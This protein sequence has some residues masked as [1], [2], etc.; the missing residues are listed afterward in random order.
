[1][2]HEIITPKRDVYIISSGAVA[3]H[4]EEAGPLGGS[5]DAVD[6]NEDR[7]GEDTW[8]KAESEMQRLAVGFALEKAGCDTTSVGAMLAGDLLNQCVGSNYGLTSY[9]IPYMGLYG[10]CSTASEGMLLGSLL[11][12]S[13]IDRAL[14]VTSSH[15]CS[16]ERQFRFPLEYG[17]QR[18][19]TAQWTVTGSGAFLLSGV[20]DDIKQL[21]S[22]YVPRIAEVLPGYVVDRGISDVNNM[23][24]AMAPAAADTLQRYFK[25]GRDPKD[26]DL[27]ITG[28]LGSEG[29]GIL[30]ELLAEEGIDISDSHVDCGC[31]IYNADE[32]DKHAGGSGCGC[33]AVVM[34]AH[35]LKNI[36]EGVVS[37]VLFVGTGALMSPLVLSQG[38]SIPGIGHLVRIK[39]EKVGK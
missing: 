20:R 21:D 7:F 6:T 37:D 24:A 22:E 3:G 35:V 39:G 19:P 15:Y 28:D 8:E 31:I 14:A 38:S 25:E 23:G 12:S 26:F 9:R 10:A 27:I 29:S 16:A 2:A 11:C 30:C 1:M 34:A 13:A 36:R 18:P 33:S 17:G 5:F 32:A 4:E